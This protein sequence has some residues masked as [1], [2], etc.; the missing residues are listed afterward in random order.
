MYFVTICAWERKILFG[1]VV[2]GTT[3]LNQTGRIVEEEWLK[4]VTLRPYVGVDA[5][6]IMPT[7]FHAIVENERRGTA[8]RAPTTR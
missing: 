8:R 7:H 1:E 2:E 5:F 6:V 3:R 4:T